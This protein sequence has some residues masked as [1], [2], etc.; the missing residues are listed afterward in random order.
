MTAMAAELSR[1]LKF[2]LPLMANS[3][4]LAVAPLK[5]AIP[6]RAP[7]T[8]NTGEEIEL[9]AMPPPAPVPLTTKACPPVIA[10]VYN[11]AVALKLMLPI[12]VK[13]DENTID[14]CVD[15]PNEAVPSGTVCGGIEIQFAPSFQLLFGGGADQD[16]SPALR[17]GAAARRTSGHA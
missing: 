17:G 3:A 14:F 2:P 12:D 13:L 5:K 6:V 4:P 16:S 9:L 15:S 11:G 8:V 10:K 1:K 7:V